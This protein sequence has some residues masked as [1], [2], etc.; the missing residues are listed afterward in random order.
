MKRRLLWSCLLMVLVLAALVGCGSPAG[1][2]DAGFFKGK[3][4]TVV[5]PHGAGGGMDTY[6]RMITPYLQKYLEGSTIVVENESG[7]GGILGRNKVFTAK[8][9]GLTL[10]FTTGT[11]MLFAEWAEKEG[12]QYKTAEFSML[13]RIY[14]EPH[15]MVVSAKSKF[16]SLKDIISAKKMT[17]GFSG[18]GSDDYYVALISAKTLGFELDPI[19]GY[20]GSNEAN[21]SAVKG[22]VD[23]VQTTYGSLKALIDAKSVIPV[24]VFG[25]KRIAELPDVPAI[26]ELTTGDSLKTMQ[27]IIGMFELDRIMMA[28][29]KMTVG[30]VKVLRDALDKAMADPEFKANSDKLKRPTLYLNSDQTLKLL[31]NI[32]AVQGQLAPIVKQVGKGGT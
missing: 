30:R 32:K 2:D 16:A 20:T 17:M 6:A 5:V 27:A 22:E 15:V 10:G 25:E 1:A 3:T 21:L 24:V 7:A 19:T 18:V 31:E 8:P 29:P 14:T 26:T 23:S 13:G 11:G 4:I 28:P 9:D 12:V